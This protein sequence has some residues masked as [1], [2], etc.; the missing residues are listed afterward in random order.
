MTADEFRENA[1]RS[2]FSRLE[3]VNYGDAI[4]RGFVMGVGRF[5]TVAQKQGVFTNI[6]DVY[7]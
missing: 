3:L 1:C 6:V 5:V 7:R 2:K 4:A